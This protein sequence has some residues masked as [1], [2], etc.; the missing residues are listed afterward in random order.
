VALFVE[1]ATAGIVYY[2]NTNPS[3]DTLTDLVFSS[4]PYT[5]I[6]DSIGL[7]SAGIASAATVQFYNDASAG[8]FSA[9]LL[10]FN[11]GL[12]VATEIGSPYTV[13]G[14]SIG[15]GSELNVTFQLGALSLPS[16]VVFLVEV[17][18]LTGG[19]DPGLELYSDPTIAGT[20]TADTAI[21]LQSAVYTQQSTGGGGSGNP[22]FDLVQS[23]EPSTWLPIAA[24]G[25]VAAAWRK[26]RRLSGG[27]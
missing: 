18:N 6:G 8:T 14:I 27:N 5:G 1:P 23:P 19:V 24:V 7:T 2:N 11:A 12:P 25:L 16:S 13:N 22:Y 26:R 15:A 17:S 10:F 3:Q 4:G 20:N 21:F 9:S